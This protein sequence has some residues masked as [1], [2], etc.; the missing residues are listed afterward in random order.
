[1][2]DINEL[3]Q[4]IDKFKRNMNDVDNIKTKLDVTIK[5]FEE[6][7]EKNKELKKDL[8]E[9][10]TQLK[11]GLLEKIDSSNMMLL[12]KNKKTDKEL[13]TIIKMLDDVFSKVKYLYFFLVL[14]VILNVITIVLLL[15]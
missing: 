4:N 13:N 11:E 14:S 12:E 3:E 6:N 15:R 9:K 10:H 7:L 1:M 5:L 8:L 2:Y